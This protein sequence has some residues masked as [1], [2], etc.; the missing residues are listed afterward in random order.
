MQDKD[1]LE[2]QGATALLRFLPGKVAGSSTPR[3]GAAVKIGGGNETGHVSSIDADA[4][5]TVTLDSG[6]ERT[7]G[8]AVPPVP[9]AL[10]ADEGPSRP[11]VTAPQSQASPRIDRRS[12]SSHA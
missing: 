11:V 9:S 8:D 1:F 7:L 3:T 10:S 4:M 6:G 5:V 2:E 12:G